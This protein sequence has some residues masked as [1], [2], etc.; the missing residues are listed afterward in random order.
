MKQFDP[1]SESFLREKFKFQNYQ[2]NNLNEN[3]NNSGIFGANNIRNKNGLLYYD[4]LDNLVP[5]RNYSSKSY[6]G[7]SID[8]S[9]STD[10]EEPH[11]NYQNN[12]KFYSNNNSLSDSFTSISSRDGS[13]RTS[14]SSNLIRDLK[15]NLNGF[16]ATKN[17]S[18]RSYTNRNL[19]LNGRFSC[20]ISER[21]SFENKNINI[22]ETT[23]KTALASSGSSIKIRKNSSSS[24]SIQA[25][26][27]PNQ[28]QNE[29]EFSYLKESDSFDKFLKRNKISK[30]VPYD[31]LNKD[32]ETPSQKLDILPDHSFNYHNNL[33]KLNYELKGKHDF[34]LNNKVNKQFKLVSLDKK[35]SNMNL[36]ISL[37]IKV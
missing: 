6:S 35:L 22:S 21:Y 24:S 36:K 30:F 14:D 33:S 29:Y 12:A 13:S 9:I 34:P 32:S 27:V 11:V 26:F 10:V 18:Y 28:C 19:F 31:N 23:R 15:Y 2:R 37:L 4:K 5:L 1:S 3:R 7:H 8:S 16:L 17:S 20:P 25:V